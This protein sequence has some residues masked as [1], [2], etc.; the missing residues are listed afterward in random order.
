MKSL[1]AH[2]LEALRWRLPPAPGTA[3]IPHDHVR[4]YHQTHA[5]NLGSIKRHGIRLA[6]AKGVEGPKGIYADDRGFYGAPDRNHT[7]EFH[8]HKSRWDRPFVRGGD[9]HPHSIVAVH[10]PW[11]AHARYADKNPDVRDS[12]RRG[13]HDDLLGDKEH[14][15]AVRFVKHGGT[16]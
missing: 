11:H 1:R 9:V 5:D 4:L 16:E 2:I 3:P 8:V 15:R 13:D 10:K 14:G 12:I 6:N 7:V